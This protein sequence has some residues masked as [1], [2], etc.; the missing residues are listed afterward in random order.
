MDKL[1]T[2]LERSGI[3]VTSL[4]PSV[5]GYRLLTDNRRSIEIWQRLRSLVPQTGYWPVLLGEV[6]D[7]DADRPKTQ[8]LDEILARRG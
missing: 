8:S 6:K 5:E 1:R 3:D 2:I 4:T 7:I